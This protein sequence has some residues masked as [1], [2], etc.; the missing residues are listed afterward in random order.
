MSRLAITLFGGFHVELDG[1]P[2]IVFGT[3]KIRLLLAYLALESGLPHRR[4]ALAALFW[5]DRPETTARN[6]LRQALH[7]L[8]YLLDQGAETEP[9]LLITTDQV[10]FNPASD[11]WVDALEFRSRLSTSQA[12]HP[13]G[14]SLCPRCLENLQ[15][16]IEL[17][18]GE[19]LDG[20]TLP[21]CT[22][23][24]DWRV[25]NQET[26]HHQA[27]AALS[28]LADYFETNLAYDQL[29]ACT[30][31]KI[32]L[33]PWRE[34][35]HRR[36]MWAFAMGGY[37]ERALRQYETLCQILQ[38]E[39]GI[40]P[41]DETRLLYE[42]IRENRLPKPCSQEEPWRQ[43][44]SPLQ[45]P[46]NGVE[47]FFVGR[48][49]ELSQLHRFLRDALLGQGRVAIV[50]GEAGSGKTALLNEFARRA[51]R[52]HADLL[53]AMGTCSA[54]NGLGDPYQPFREVLEMLAG[55][56]DSPRAGA[57]I[58]T[59]QAW[60]LSA[61]LP[62]F[63]QTLLETSPGLISSLLNAQKLL[64]YARK[65]TD[66]NDAI[67]RRLESL[68]AYL[69]REG[70]T[71]SRPGPQIAFPASPPS[72]WAQTDLFDQLARLLLAL[73]RRYPLL[74]LL[75]DLQ[76][77]DSASASLLFH[78][79]GRL[80]G[81]RILLVVAYR[82]EDIL[83]SG[84]G[85]RHPLVAVLNEFQRRF[86]DIQIDLSHVDGRLFVQAFLDSQPNHFDQDFREI[87]YRHT[88]GNP[89]FT[90]ELLHTMQEYGEVVQDKTDHWVVGD[91]VD[92]ERIPRRVEAILA[93]R[94]GRLDRESLALLES[95]SV[96]GE[97]FYAQVLAQV[98]GVTEEEITASLGRSLYKEHRLV[99]SLC[100]AQQDSDGQVPYQFCNFLYPKYLYRSLDEVVRRRLHRAT[101]EAMERLDAAQKGKPDTSPVRTASLA[102]HFEQAGLTGKAVEYYLKTG[103]DACGQSAFQPAMMNLERGLR[104][105]K[106]LPDTPER[107][108]LELAYLFNLNRVIATK[109]YPASQEHIPVLRRAL[110][111][112]QE[113]KRFP[114]QIQALFMQWSY[115]DLRGENHRCLDLAHQMLELAEKL[116]DPI[117]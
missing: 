25:Y 68:A 108:R 80:S 93:E 61:A 74:I 48:Q 106:E 85:K 54:Y 1:Y 55:I 95:A 110:E 15:R 58:S 35:A 94:L 82:P 81:G 18:R 114:E 100:L 103:E 14:S 96:Q 56:G 79:G 98:M 71:V 36:Q 21:R 22:R 6:S 11:H 27:L 3:D 9:H 63:L 112:C 46:I 102:W 17:Y 30:Q 105:L 51:M 89:L 113:L 67:L 62:V 26:C 28:L 50:S 49:P 10:Q 75:D 33:E 99:S 43:F 24:T 69:D 83:T 23:F 116:K 20:L 78:L 8:H 2:L 4:E 70:P 57:V 41:L 31:R 40:S 13:P 107:A 29:I 104:L 66:L 47:A 12:H 117:V 7:Q 53:V 91:K 5:P 44:G 16:A 59:E 39:F 65:A 90:V 86:G 34:S 37:R 84:D 42:Q 115:H 109:E 87:L 72:F 32:E 73:S 76:W 52:A 111:R 92:W 19:M 60:R 64:P 45:S 88:R 97:V 38:R 77:S 101:A